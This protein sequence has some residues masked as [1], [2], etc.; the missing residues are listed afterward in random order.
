[1]AKHKDPIIAPAAKCPV[2]GCFLSAYGQTVYKGG[3]VPKH[4]G[5]SVAKGTLVKE[6]PDLKSWLWSPASG[7]IFTD[8]EGWRIAVTYTANMMVHF[9]ADHPKHGHESDSMGIGGWW[10]RHCEAVYVPTYES[11]RGVSVVRLGGVAIGVATDEQACAVAFSL[12][13]GDHLGWDWGGKD[14]F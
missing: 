8:K 12:V 5:C 11:Y 9:E 6:G 10:I 7:D 1:M 2:C 3:I 14:G 4:Y 13:R